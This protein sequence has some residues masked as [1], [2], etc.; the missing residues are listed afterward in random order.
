MSLRQGG[1]ALSLSE[2]VVIKNVMGGADEKEINPNVTMCQ[3][4]M[5]YLE[6][7]MT[8]TLPTNNILTFS[9]MALGI[10]TVRLTTHSMTTFSIM[11]FS[12]T[13]LF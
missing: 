2:K 7:D 11:T 3:R 6:S 13:I 1:C 4:M 9:L 5:W 8:I 12:I 10:M